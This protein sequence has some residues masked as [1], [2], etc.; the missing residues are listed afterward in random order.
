MTY[1]AIVAKAADRCAKADAKNIQ[2][3][4]ALQVNIYGEGEGALYI[5]V[6]NK[7]MDVQPFEYYD[8]DAIIW[9]PAELFHEAICGYVPMDEF[10]KDE[11]VLVEGDPAKAAVLTEIKFRK[12]RRIAKKAEGE[13][14]ASA[15][16]T[17][18]KKAP[19]KKAAKKA[20]KQ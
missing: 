15:K 14:K 4:V 19:A 2:E 13:K 18:A 7:K 9:S 6:E 16:K 3:H 5:E 17:P 10:L 8:R 20:D 11:K 1:E 12:E